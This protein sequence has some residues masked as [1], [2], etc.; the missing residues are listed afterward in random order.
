M[1][2]LSKISND[3]LYISIQLFQRCLI[4][5]LN[6]DLWKCYLN[7]VRDTKGILPT[8]RLDF[9]LIYLDLI[10]NRQSIDNITRE[11]NHTRVLFTFVIHSLKIKKQQ[12]KISFVLSLIIFLNISIILIYI[13]VY[14]FLSLLFSC[15]FTC[16]FFSK[17][18]H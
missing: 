2:R 11:N 6:I 12:N 16:S 9:L 15:T 3:D 18:I 7:Y 10:F 8:F 5:V 13:Y 4:K 1:M 17:W 14:L